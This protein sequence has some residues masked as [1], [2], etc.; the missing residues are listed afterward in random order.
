MVPFPPPFLQYALGLFIPVS[1]S[2]RRW[3]EDSVIAVL[4]VRTSWGRGLNC[5]MILCVPITCFSDEGVKRFSLRADLLERVIG[6]GGSLVNFGLFNL[7]E[8]T[9]RWD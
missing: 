3:G 6:V 8:W 9:V 5:L 7:E 2:P 4:V 1:E